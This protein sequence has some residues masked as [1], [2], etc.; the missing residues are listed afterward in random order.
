DRL[1]ELV[2]KLNKVERPYELSMFYDCQV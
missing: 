1:Y 2:K